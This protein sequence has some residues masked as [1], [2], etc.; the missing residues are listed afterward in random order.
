MISNKIV[1]FPTVFTALIL[2]DPAFA[3]DGIPDSA[4][5]AWMLTA[6]LLVLMMTIPGVALVYGGMVRKKNVLSTLMHSFAATALIS[7]VWVA[8]GYS[9]AFSKGNLFIGGLSKVLLWD[10]TVEAMSGSIPETVFI[11]C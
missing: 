6:T 7:V 9:L 3:D 10:L 2:G 11:N 4:D 8:V 1:I 5:T